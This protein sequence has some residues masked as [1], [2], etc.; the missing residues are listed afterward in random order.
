MGL[1]FSIMLLCMMYGLFKALTGRQLPEPV[2]RATLGT[3]S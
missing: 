3:R 2:G 1:P